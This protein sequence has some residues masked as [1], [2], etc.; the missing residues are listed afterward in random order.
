M[1]TLDPL[2]YLRSKRVLQRGHSI[3]SILPLIGITGMIKNK[4][5]NRIAVFSMNCVNVPQA[6]Q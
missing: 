6:L 2:T 3:I 1:T 4:V 5:T